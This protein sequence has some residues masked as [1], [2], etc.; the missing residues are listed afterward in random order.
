M[1]PPISAKFKNGQTPIEGEK[2]NNEIF[3][4]NGEYIGGQL[5]KKA[6]GSTSVGLIQSIFND[7][8]FRE[9]G[10]FIN[11]LQNLITDYMKLS[12]YSVGISD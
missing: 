12:G 10:S 6:L 4:K 5:D 11:N 2:K 7:F 1:L 3:I 8:G 9:S